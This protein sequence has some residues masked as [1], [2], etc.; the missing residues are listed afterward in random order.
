MSCFA[1]R[2]VYQPFSANDENRRA[3]SQ[4]VPPENQANT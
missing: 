4:K 3:H 1:K 2:Y